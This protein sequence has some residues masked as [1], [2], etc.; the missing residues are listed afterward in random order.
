M[1]GRFVRDKSTGVPKIAWRFWLLLL[2]S[3]GFV[4]AENLFDFRLSIPS[5]LKAS[6]GLPLLDMRLWYT[7]ADAYQLFDTLGPAGRADYRLLYLTVDI[8]IPLLITTL[9]WSGISRGALKRFRVLGMLGGAFD[10]LENITVLILLAKYPEHLSYLVIIAAGFTLL[11]AVS[12]V[13]GACL[14]IIGFLIKVFRRR[15]PV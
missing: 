12:Y 9:L 5:M 3:I 8:I 11:K 4:A 14:A 1:I 10:Y 7:P 2:L 6:G 15:A 13:S